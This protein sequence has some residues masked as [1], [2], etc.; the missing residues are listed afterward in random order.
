MGLQIGNSSAAR[1]GG[2][3]MLTDSE[4]PYWRHAV[5]R[6][7]WEPAPPRPPSGRSSA[8]ARRSSPVDTPTAATGR[9]RVACGVAMITWRTPAWAP[10]TPDDGK[11]RCFIEA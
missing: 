9:Y 8:A 6:D 3:V 1:I 2:V 11:V 7:N 10:T 4:L 5:L